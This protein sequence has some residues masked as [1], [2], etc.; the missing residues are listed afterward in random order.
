MKSLLP[1][2]LCGAGL[3]SGC[4]YFGIYRHHPAERASPEEAAAVR[5]PDSLEQ[6][7]RLTGPMMAAL[8]V[9]MDDYRP[10]GMR[11]EKLQPPD[12]CLANWKYIQT[13]VLQVSDTLF[14]AEFAPDLRTCGPGYILLDAGA[15]YAIDDKGRI[16]GRE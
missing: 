15:T 13:T 5:F 16:L 11:P 10:P 3:L 6:G 7:V 14:F 4:G 2:V 12:S 1:L 8:K 9:A